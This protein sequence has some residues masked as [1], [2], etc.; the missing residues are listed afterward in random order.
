M[1]MIPLARIVP[2]RNARTVAV[3]PEHDAGLRRSIA[4]AGVLQ[5]VVLRPLGT[6]FDATAALELVLGNRRFA[7]ATALGLIEI[8]A[9]IRVMTDAEVAAAQVAENVQRQA[10]HPVDQWRQMRVLIQDH[11]YSFEQAAGALGLDERLTRRMEQLGRLNPTLLKL[12]EIE[13]PAPAQLRKIAAAPAKLQGTAAAIKGV[14]IMR[15]AAE[16]VDWHRVVSACERRRISRSVAIF[17]TE[18]RKIPWDEDLFAEPGADDQFTTAD[19]DTFMKHQTKALQV[20]V[21]EL[22]KARKRHQVAVMKDARAIAFP[23]G[24]KASFGKPERLRT[25]EWA[26]HA[27]NPDGT[28]RIETALDT[29]AVKKA[30]NAAPDGGQGAVAA[31][32]LRPDDAADDDAPDGKG[33]DA[34]P[35]PT[36]DPTPEPEAPRP[37]N[38]RGMMLIAAAKGAALRK[39]LDEAALPPGRVIALLI[40]ALCADNVDIRGVP[41]GHF[42]D[43]ATRLL[44]PGGQLLEVSD[45]D[46]CAMGQTALG[47]L[48][49]VGTPEAGRTA[50]GWA[51]EWIGA[52]IGADAGLD[53]FD[54]QDFLTTASLAELKRAAAGA[55]LLATGTA[56]NL[57]ER[58]TGCAPAYRPEP[59]AF[60][61]PVPRKQAAREPLAT[62]QKMTDRA[63]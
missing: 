11:D 36:P 40:L 31:G 29:K 62:E 14:V 49:H 18:A 42:A 44:A 45:A 59:S 2:G 16:T 3:P 25:H 8:P 39:T 50:S 63:A 10:M 37:F 5:P 47:R 33:Q 28:I 43:L 17:D 56:A 34:A 26:F 20:R 24:F 52:A 12:A 4:A 57:R 38:R 54:S 53:R 21:A 13:M 15:G 55:A 60:G 41:D 32:A 6:P 22:V 48:L 35:D 9:E 1:P 27:I 19:V 23:G 30:A 58:L 7:A 46:L 61:A 51:A